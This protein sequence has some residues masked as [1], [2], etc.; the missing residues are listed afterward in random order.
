MCVTDVS[1]ACDVPDVL[2]VCLRCVNSVLQMCVTYLFTDVSQAC[3]TCVAGVS[4]VCV[5]GILRVC[6][7]Y[8]TC[9][10]NEYSGVSKGLCMRV[11]SVSR[12]CYMCITTV[13]QVSCMSCLIQY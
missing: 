2:Q 3:Y 1:Q 9:V 6:N 12:V 8:F 5:T 13:L 10:L 4:P 7:I 11:T